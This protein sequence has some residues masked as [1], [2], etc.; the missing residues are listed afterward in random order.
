MA[1]GWKSVLEGVNPE[2]IGDLGSDC[3][4]ARH[5][6]APVD[7]VSGTLAGVAGPGSLLIDVTGMNLYI[8]GGTKTSPAWKLVTRAA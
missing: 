2:V 1:K 5:N 7:G 8:N 3:V 4:I 6:A